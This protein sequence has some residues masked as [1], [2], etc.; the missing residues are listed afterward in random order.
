MIE[1]KNSPEAKDSRLTPPPDQ[2]FKKFTTSVENSQLIYS[3][4]LLALY[5][6]NNFPILIFACNHDDDLY[7]ADLI[8]QMFLQQTHLFLPQITRDCEK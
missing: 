6:P 2:P 7:L 4:E 8:Y 1:H 5:H 3:Q